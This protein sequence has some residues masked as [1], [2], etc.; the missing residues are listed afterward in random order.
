M[1][2]KKTHTHTHTVRRRWSDGCNLQVK[3]FTKEYE[4]T[5]HECI[6]DQRYALVINRVFEGGRHLQSFDEGIE[7]EDPLIQ[8]MEG[9]RRLSK[10]RFVDREAP[11]LISFPHDLSCLG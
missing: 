4:I 1:N 3:D 9:V 10:L 2:G 8:W 5:A 6:P 7:T 11:F